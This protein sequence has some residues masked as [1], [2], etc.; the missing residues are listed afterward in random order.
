MRWQSVL[1]C[2]LFVSPNARM[3]SYYA[4]HW[5]RL[6]D[7]RMF[8]YYARH[9]LRLEDEKANRVTQGIDFVYPYRKEMK[10][11][12]MLQ[13]SWSAG[14]FAMSCWTKEIDFS[15]TRFRS[16]DLWVMSP[17]RFLCATELPVKSC[18]MYGNKLCR[19]AKPINKYSITLYQIRQ[20]RVVTKSK[21]ASIDFV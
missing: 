11:Q 16:S 19:A 20:N 12:I 1:Q 18:C 6:E 4:R 10:R 21:Y 14:I 5:L 15:S 7:A 13:I 17:T 2:C 3:F 8:S 9:W